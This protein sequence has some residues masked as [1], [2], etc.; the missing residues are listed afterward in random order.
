MTTFT[1]KKASISHKD[2]IF[3]WLAKP[4]IQEFWDNSSEHKEDILIFLEGRKKTSTYFKGSFTYWIGYIN[5]DPFAFIMTSEILPKEDIPQ[6]WKEHLSKTGKTIGIDFC[7]GNEEYLGKGYAAKTLE[8][9]TDYIKKSNSQIDRFYI[10][11]DESNPKAT[12]VYEKAG[13]KKVGSF[14]VEKGFFKDHESLLMIK[15]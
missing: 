15:T 5:N 12:R 14:S 7:I 9:F 11:P 4:H 2:L 1:F 13:F 8:A 3:S 10:D 6:I